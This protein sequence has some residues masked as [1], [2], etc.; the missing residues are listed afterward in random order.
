MTEEIEKKTE[1]SKK[2]PSIYARMAEARARLDSKLLKKGGLNEY[3]KA[4]YFE[5][6]DFLPHVNAIC[7]EL[8]MLPVMT[9]N[10]NREEIEA[11]LDIYD[12]DDD[13]PT[14][15]KRVHFNMPLAEVNLNT[16]NSQ[17]IQE[18]GAMQ[19]YAMRYLYMNAF[20]ISEVDI[21]DATYSNFTEEQKLLIK[22]LQEAGYSIE[23]MAKAYGTPIP[24]LTAAQLR[25]AVKRKLKDKADEILGKIPV[26]TQDDGKSGFRDKISKALSEKKES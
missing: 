18:F 6:A 14:F 24:D 3:N 8:K 7:S 19:T 17:K 25:D 26:E 21:L 16:K 2:A 12:G 13:S 4:P 15:E 9:F 22:A 5:L 10:N 11:Y 1:N 23:S 20:A